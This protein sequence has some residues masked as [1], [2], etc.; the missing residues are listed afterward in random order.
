MKVAVTGA[1][2]FVGRAVVARL[3][4]AGLPTIAISRAPSA[5]AVVDTRRLPSPDAPEPEFAA[6]LDGIT[7]VVHGAGLTNAAPDTPEQ[8]Y[9]AANAEL[10]A[11][12]ASTARSAGVQRFILL[13]S[14]RAVVGA[15]FDGTIGEAT[16]PAPT[17]AYGRSKL[18]AEQAAAAAFADQPERLTILRLAPVY[19]VGMGGNLA[20]LLRLADTGLPLPF[21]GFSATRT[22]VA[23]EAVADLVHALLT[24]QAV[25]RRHYL[26]GDGRGTTLPEI[27]S[28]FRQ[29]LNR[30]RRL[31]QIPPSLLGAVASVTG[32]S[33][34]F[35]AL[36]ASQVCDTSA[37][38]ADHLPQRPESLTGL[39]RVAEARLS[40]AEKPS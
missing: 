32:K 3:G 13:S 21:G 14:I 37:L 35:R 7:H 38:A 17:D 12:L 36:A 8:E 22:L 11:R 18:A 26:V 6:T 2:G 25:S 39:R 40:G 33:E 4:E 5:N 31:L 34:T 15:S 28:A 19:G 29:G 9:L 20:R 23:V 10:T 24:A 16:P 27:I 30:P 1:G